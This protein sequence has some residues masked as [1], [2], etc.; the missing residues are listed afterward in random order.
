MTGG[1]RF[2]EVRF[3]GVRVP[4]AHRV[5]PEHGGWSLARTTLGHERSTS[6][7]SA[8]L[9]YRR[10]VKELIDLA[11]DAGRAGDPLVRQELARLTVECNLLVATSQRIVA[12]LARSEQPGAASSVFR[13]AHARFEQHLHEVALSV[14]GAAGM[15]ASDDQ[16]SP[17]QGRWTWGFLNTRASTIGAGTA[18][19][20]RNTIAEK[21]LGLPR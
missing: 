15:L 8:I 2:N 11:R 12:E 21:V 6:R 1:F 7:V 19:I 5:G 20:Q 9:R 14:I 13:L 4:V 18:E 3:D 17:Q 16:F 10:I